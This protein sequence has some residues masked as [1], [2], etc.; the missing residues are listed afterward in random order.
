MSGSAL[1]D[2]ARYGKL[3]QKIVAQDDQYPAAFA[4]A[5]TAAS[6]VIGPIVPP[7]D[8]LVVY[9]LIATRASATCSSAASSRYLRSG[10]PSGPD[11]LRREAPHFPVEPP[12][13]L[14][15]SPR[16]TWQAFPA[17]LMPVVL[18]GGIYSGV[19]TPTEAAAIAAAYSLV[20]SAALYRSVSW[21]NLYDALLNSARTARRSAS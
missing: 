21:R 20:V 17:L 19:T 3:M 12:T 11:R 18:L 4:A 9:A 6:S 8:P 7:L 2:A 13:P 15:D 5:L 16:I 14:R 1:A 10:S